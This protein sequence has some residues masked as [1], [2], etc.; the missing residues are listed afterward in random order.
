MV[1]HTHTIHR[2]TAGE[3]FECVWPFCWVGAE[4]VKIK[5]KFKKYSLKNILRSLRLFPVS[6]IWSSSGLVSGSCLCDIVIN[7]SKLSSLRARL[8]FIM[9]WPIFW[10]PTFNNSFCVRNYHCLERL[11][12]LDNL[13][14]DLDGYRIFHFTYYSF[15]FSLDFRNRIFC[16]IFI[17]FL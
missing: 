7:M 6:I 1:K 12:V 4:R 17:C 9:I 10:E 16:R 8:F 14:E 2:Q 15:N 11:L 5:E 3:L 13:W